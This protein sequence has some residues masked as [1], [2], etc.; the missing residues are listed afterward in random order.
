MKNKT[1]YLATLYLLFLALLLTSG[2][3]SGVLS[4]VVYIVAFLLPSAMG[5]SLAYREKKNISDTLHL[6][7]RENIS[8]FVP[9]IFP[10]ISLVL[11]ISIL[12]SVIMRFLFGVTSGVELDN[13]IFTAIIMHALVP[14]LL[15]EMLF[16]YLPLCLYEKGDGR[17]LVVI[18]A[19]FFALVHNDFFVIPYAF[20]AGV[21]FM[22]VD[23]VCESVWPSVVLHFLNNLLSVLL[24]FYSGNC[25]FI[26]LF[27]GI[28]ILLS[29]I[30]LAFIAGKGKLYKEKVQSALSGE[31]ARPTKEFLYLAVPTLILAVSDLVSKI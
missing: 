5:V 28:L 26:Y 6:P 9:V 31:K 25:T 19:L 15:E 11:F 10:S 20:I 3:L 23:L 7:N 1:G 16:R 27:Y 4:E 24:I 13:N 21:I 14:A 8:L 18:S 30:S 29:A 17:S 22:T 12:T 2:M